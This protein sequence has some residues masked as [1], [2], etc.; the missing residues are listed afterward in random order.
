MGAQS[1][2]VSQALSIPEA[3]LPAPLWIVLNDAPTV[4]EVASLQ[5]E[6]RALSRHTGNPAY[7]AVAQRVMAHLR[8][9]TSGK[10]LQKA[11]RFCSGVAVPMPALFNVESSP[12]SL[13][14][15]AQSWLEYF[16][17]AL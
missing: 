11:A 5:L 4:A 1:S 10:Q 14:K 8:A 15:I 17:Y 13:S 12:R 6:F 16:R 7:E 9:S 2:N 3:T